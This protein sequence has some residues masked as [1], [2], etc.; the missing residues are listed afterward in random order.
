[1]GSPLK[2]TSYLSLGASAKAN[3]VFSEAGLIQS[4]LGAGV[5]RHWVG[6]R[7]DLLS[8][9]IRKGLGVLAIRAF[10]LELKSM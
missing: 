9:G 4:K 7:Q 5:Q 3:Q 8:S 6:G 1:M 2:D 10:C